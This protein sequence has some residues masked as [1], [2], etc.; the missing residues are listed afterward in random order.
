[1]EITDIK[2]RLSI[3]QVLVYKYVHV[4]LVV[5]TFSCKLSDEKQPIN[6]DEKLIPITT[7]DKIRT[8]I[9]ENAGIVIPGY[10]MC[11]SKSDQAM[12]DYSESYVIKFDSLN[13]QNIVIQIKNSQYYMGV[14]NPS[15]PPNAGLKEEKLKRWSKADFGYRFEYFMDGTDKLLEFEVDTS[16]Y[17]IY[18]LYI[19][20]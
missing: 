1:M 5:F 15:L 10:T 17:S 3:S 12:G 6:D 2:S 11:E 7:D 4:L 20:E 14:C 13:F 9:K 18:R 16:D 19:E 8:E